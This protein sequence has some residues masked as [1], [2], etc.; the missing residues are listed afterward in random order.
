MK[1]KELI[2]SVVDGGKTPFEL[3]RDEIYGEPNK[4]FGSAKEPTP[5]KREDT[6]QSLFKEGD[7]V[8]DKEH[9]KLAQVIEV[10]EDGK[11]KMQRTGFLGAYIQT[12]TELV[13]HDTLA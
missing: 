10:L 12:E 3:V 7:A 8:W 2:E 4:T 6:G 11:Y 13:K 9:K 5:P 1:S